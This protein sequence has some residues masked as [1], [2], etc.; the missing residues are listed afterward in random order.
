MAQLKLE[1][2]RLKQHLTERAALVPLATA[3]AS[4]LAA[5]SS[6]V[7]LSTTADVAKVPKPGWVAVGPLCEEV[8]ALSCFL[9]WSKC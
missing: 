6:A 1:N 3:T 8:A 4:H 7:I 5:T 2:A 9:A